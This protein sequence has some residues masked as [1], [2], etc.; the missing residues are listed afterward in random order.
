M[1]ALKDGTIQ[2]HGIPEEVV[3][4][5]LLVAV[6]EIDAEIEITDPG[7]RMTPIRARHDDRNGDSKSEQ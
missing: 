7:P 1:V 5:E 3:T 2:A 6:F 4:E